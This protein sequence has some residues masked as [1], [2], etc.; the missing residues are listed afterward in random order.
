MSGTKKILE[1]L[2]N[3]SVVSI[4]LTDNKNQMNIMDGCDL[5]Y[6]KRSVFLSKDEVKQLIEELTSLHNEMI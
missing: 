6:D 1:R 4:V 2:E 3:G 5:Y